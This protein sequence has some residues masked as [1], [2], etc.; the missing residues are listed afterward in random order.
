MAKQRRSPSRQA[1]PEGMVRRETLV[2]VTAAALVVG[3]A[4]GMVFTVYKS[5]AGLGAPR[6]PA[7]AARPAPSAV[8]QAAAPSP[9]LME[10]IR[11]MEQETA[12][13]PDNVFAW[14]ALGNAYFDTHQPAKAI[15]AYEKALRQ[16]PEHADVWTDLGVMYRRDGQ[17]AKALEAFDQAVQIDPKHEIARFNKGVV[18]LHDIGDKEKALKAW[19]EL[20][21]INPNAGT[22]GGQSLRQLMEHYRS[23]EGG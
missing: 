11:Q 21:K 23:H 7:P 3:F 8:P 4:L 16:D 17:P 6:A 1:I 9:E 18:L 13:N 22:P 19:E 12:E 5:T 10:R 15:E 2:F 20:L 14:I